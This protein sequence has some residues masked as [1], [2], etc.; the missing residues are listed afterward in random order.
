MFPLRCINK[1]LERGYSFAGVEG[2]KQCW[3]GNTEPPR[4]TFKPDGDCN[5]DC[6]G[7]RRMHCGGD[8]RMQVYSTAPVFPTGTIF[9][10]GGTRRQSLS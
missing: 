5:F 6:A 7:D 9:L 4:S 3:C 2:Y 10:G 1:C 8:W